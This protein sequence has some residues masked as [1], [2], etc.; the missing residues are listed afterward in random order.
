MMFIINQATSR[1]MLKQGKQANDIKKT[2]KRQVPA[3]K[4]P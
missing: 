2:S 1:F 4:I 3:P